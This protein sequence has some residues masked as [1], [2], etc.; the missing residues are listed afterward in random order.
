MEDGSAELTYE[1]TGNTN[2]GLFSFVGIDS[3]GMLLIR[4]RPG[5]PGTANITVRATDTLGKSVASTMTVTVALADTYSHWSGGGALSGLSGYA[6]GLSPQGGDVAGLPRIKIQN[7]ARVVTHLKPTWATDLTYQYE[8]SQ[9]L[10]TWI[11]AVREVHFHEFA[12]DLPNA[13]RQSDCVLLVN[14]PKAY[15]RVR[16]VLAP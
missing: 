14:W 10:V 2:P 7:K 8:L 4:Y 1:V 9:D 16:A 11:P 5:I 12:K 13:I 3:A 6:F 15:M